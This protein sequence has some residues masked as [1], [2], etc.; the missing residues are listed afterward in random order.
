MAI[1]SSISHPRMSNIPVLGHG[2]RDLCIGFAVVQLVIAVVVGSLWEFYGEEARRR[3]G[4]VMKLE[5]SGATGRGTSGG[6]EGSFF[7]TD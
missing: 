3:D 1:P 6:R 2:L 5:D 4:Q 7:D